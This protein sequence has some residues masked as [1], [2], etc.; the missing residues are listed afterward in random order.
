M[1]KLSKKLGKIKYS[2]LVIFILSLSFYLGV[3]VST[4][5]AQS[6]EFHSLR[7]YQADPWNTEV[8]D[9]ALF[10]GNNLIVADT[11]T[12][13]RNDAQS[14]TPLSNGKERCSFVISNSK[15]IL[16]D[17]SG[18]DLPILGNTENVVN[19]NKSSDNS[20]FED[21]EKTNEYV[22]WYLNGTTG[23]AEYPFLDSTNEEDLSKI[24]D[25]SGPLKKLLPWNEQAR[26]RIKTI[27]RVVDKNKDINKDGVIEEQDR[28][29][30]I[31]ACT[32][33]VPIKLFGQWEVARVAEVPVPCYN[34]GFL[35]SFANFFN[36]KDEKKISEW[37][38]H[39]PP[40][41]ENFEDF[42][43]YWVAYK[44]WR[45]ERC[46]IAE[47][48]NLIPVIGG[49]KFFY[50]FDDPTKPNYW[51]NLFPYIPFSSTE[52][53]VGLVE[54]QSITT[55]S[56][57]ADVVL[58]EVTFDNQEP[59]EL[60]FA[61]AEEVAELASI[62]QKTFVPQGQENNLSPSG[63]MTSEYCDLVNI[64]T[65]EGDD[66]FA[67]EIS[68]TLAY[69]AEF[70]CDLRSSGNACE[71]A[72]GVCLSVPSCSRVGEGTINGGSGCSSV[73]EICCT[74]GEP[75]TE[76]ECKKEIYANLSVI[77]ETPMVNE[78]W[79]RLVA[80]SSGVFKRMF[81]KI[82]P[83]TDLGCV[84]DIPGATNVTYSGEGLI[85]AGNPG[86]ERS[87]E[88]AE[89][90][91]PHLG[92]ISEYFLKGTQT[93]LRPKGYGENIVF[94][95]PGDPLCI[96]NSSNVDICSND[97][98]N[99][100]SN[101]NMAG[102]KEK[103]E[104]LA[105]R[106][107]ASGSPRTDKYEQVVSASLSRGVDP[108]FTLA[109]WLHESGASNYLGICN[110]FGGG[111]PSSLY[112]QRIQDF[113]INLPEAETIINS[114]GAIIEDNFSNQ[115]GRFVNLPGY[116]LSACDVNSVN[117]P[118]E[119]FGAMYTSTGSCTPTDS[120]NG[121]VTGILEIYR[122]LSSTQQLPCYPISVSN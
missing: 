7:P 73:S 68:G 77:T 22:S 45:G 121:Y 13:T 117:C 111:D 29:D 95:S 90:Y 53:R 58:K 60:F 24:I 76:Q 115:L 54:T 84:L 47:V 65:N 42:A 16:I 116:Y 103:F 25:F 5:F 88:S 17:L 98:N 62:L 8:S 93:L 43:D 20:D 14:C 78:I 12:V 6:D 85:Y 92:G 28:H 51:A 46:A 102:V 105:N 79:A 21:A 59:A 104:D 40:L 34:E 26:S 74:G 114:S 3:F 109:I 66:L 27:E 50:C 4:S 11:I 67:G 38:N 48:P 23:R 2:L 36:L 35:S 32:Y 110:Q 39:L 89:L 37:K 107:L 100:P 70:T 10:C 71:Q 41:A 56:P 120:S 30:Q 33:G 44:R 75:A 119:I 19:I 122:W 80:G 15:D 81:P 91:F 49:K 96:E 64:R 97:C 18:A 118:W 83:N 63:V 112:C 61:H 94:G 55:T 99:T 52:D 57:S 87:G 101:V 108:I 1:Y 69:T 106:W 72:G 82:G 31:V 9:T 86:S 113:G